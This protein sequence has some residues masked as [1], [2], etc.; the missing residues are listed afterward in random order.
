[1]VSV[2][3][4]HHVY[5]LPLPTLATSGGKTNAYNRGHNLCTTEGHRLAKKIASTSIQNLAT[6]ERDDDR[7]VNN[8]LL[9]PNNYNGYITPK[10]RE[11]G[12]QL[13]F[14]A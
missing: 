10:Q 7:Q 8:C 12:K 6:Q 5:L 3:V 11:R 2:D 9:T 13:V 1:M 14:N 4:K